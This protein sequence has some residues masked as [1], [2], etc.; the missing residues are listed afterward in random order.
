MG[1]QQTKSKLIVASDVENGNDTHHS[2]S[3]VLFGAER[4]PALQ[5]FQD[6]A[7]RFRSSKLKCS[8]EKL[9]C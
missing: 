4:T 7:D 5:K 9:S 2:A 3:G 8:E 6:A 1:C